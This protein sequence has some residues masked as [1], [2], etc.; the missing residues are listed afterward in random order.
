MPPL[1]RAALYWTFGFAPPDGPDP[2]QLRPRPD[3]AG[4]RLRDDLSPAERAKA[5]KIGRLGYKSAG[6]TRQ[7]FWKPPE[8][9]SEQ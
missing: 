3:A 9:G 7:A 8:G 1:S 5:R 4:G 6:A 2:P